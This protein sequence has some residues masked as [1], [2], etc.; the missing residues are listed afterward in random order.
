MLTI[1]RGSFTRV[2]VATPAV[3]ENPPKL[4]YGIAMPGPFRAASNAVVVGYP[5]EMRPLQLWTMPAPCE[6]VWASTPL[7]TTILR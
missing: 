6:F 4:R 2:N 1:N 3:L 5:S 7:M